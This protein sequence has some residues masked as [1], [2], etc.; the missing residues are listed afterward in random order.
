[1]GLAILL[2]PLLPVLGLPVVWLPILLTRRLTALR[3]SVLLIDRVAV[4]LAALRLVLGLSV[5]RGLQ[6]W[7]LLAV[8]GQAVLGLAILRRAVVGGLILV[9]LQG[10][11]VGWNLASI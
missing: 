4:L 2:A 5:K 10:Q 11:L 6:W 3:L 1:M 9:F 8:L 7:K